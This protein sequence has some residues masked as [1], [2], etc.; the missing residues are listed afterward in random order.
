MDYNI[1]EQTVEIC[2]VQKIG[3]ATNVGRAMRQRHFSKKNTVNSDESAA[4]SV[5]KKVKR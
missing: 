3:D 4:D 1:W 2:V 5:K